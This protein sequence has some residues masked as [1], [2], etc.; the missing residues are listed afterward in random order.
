VLLV[1][2]ALYQR[3]RERAAA[4]REGTAGVLAAVTL[5]L[6]AD[7]IAG[8]RLG[9]HLPRED[10]VAL[11]REA[12]HLR[13]GR[14]EEVYGQGDAADAVF[15]LLSGMVQIQTWDSDRGAPEVCAHLGRGDLFGDDELDGEARRRTAAV[16]QGPSWLL[17]LAAETWRSLLRRHPTMDPASLRRVD[18]TLVA[19]RAVPGTTAQVMRDRYRLSVAKSLLVIDQSSCVRCGHCAWSCASVHDDGVSRLLREGDKLVLETDGGLRP[20]LVPSSCQHC[21]VATCMQDCPTG[22]IGRSAK[23]EIQIR[24]DLCIGC[25]NCARGCP[26]DNIQ[27]TTPKGRSLPLATKCDLCADRTGGPA[28]VAA[29]P[30]AAVVRLDPDVALG[31]VTQA[32]VK[33]EAALLPPRPPVVPFAAVAAMLG[34]GLVASSMGARTAGRLAFGVMLLLGAYSPI[35]RALL[36]RGKLGPAW[37]HYGVHVGLGSLLPFLVLAHLRGR[38]GTPLAEIAG[39]TVFI[40]VSLGVAA[41]L[42]FALLPRVLG[43]L[44][45]LPLLPE[46]MS[47]R[48][49][50]LE[51]ELFAALSGRSAT[52]KALY[53]TTIGPY[54]QSAVVG[55]LRLALSGLGIEE[56]RRR[57]SAL[58][59]SLSGPNGPAPKLS[60]LPRLVSLAVD[61]RAHGTV[62]WTMGA[63]RVLPTLHIAFAALALLTVLAHV[64]YAV[65]PW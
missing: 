19:K 4:G 3:V 7:L 23:G 18:T 49:E 54:V 53:Q 6:A 58:A 24:E 38:Q 44:D 27:M 21:K 64:V 13:L 43:R 62:R 40:A 65:H 42:A 2:T 22:A 48:R 35:K 9:A 20:L 39:Y 46:S 63:L 55:P 45:R 33:G 47:R 36:P 52:V 34:A 37:A 61:L 56:E 60:G 30:T 25:G 15:V 16:A 14:G 12:T 29:C 11:A 31:D 10:R 5:G 8:T 1:P 50:G 41:G 59:S 32:R 28:C 26:W 57:L 17:K 51:R